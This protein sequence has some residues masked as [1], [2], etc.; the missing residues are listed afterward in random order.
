MSVTFN[1]FATA[2]ATM[3]ISSAGAVA[4]D[5]RST[6]HHTGGGVGQDLHE[7][8]RIALDE[9]LRVGGERHLRDPDLATGRERVR[10]GQ[11]DIGDLG[12]R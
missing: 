5:D 6:E 11:T 3:P 10:L 4:T 2:T 7:A 8:P 1:L 12:A 9:R